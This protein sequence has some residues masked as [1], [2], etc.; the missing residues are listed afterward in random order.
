MKPVKN[1]MAFLLGTVV[2]AGTAQ[3][4]VAMQPMTF[5]IFGQYQTNRIFTNNLSTNEQRDIRTVEFSTVDV[6]KA[7]ALDHAGRHW[8]NLSYAIIARET[9]FN[10]GT[11]GREGIFLYRNSPPTN[12]NVSSNFALNFTNDFTQN[13][14]NIFPG[15]TNLGVNHTIIGGT[16]PSGSTN[17]GSLVSDG[18][19]SIT[20]YTTNMQ[21]NLIGYGT[22]TETNLAGS[23]AGVHYS[24]PVQTLR[25]LTGVGTFGLNIA[26]NFF[27]NS[28]VGIPNSNFVS[29]PAHGYFRTGAPVF[30]TNSAASVFGP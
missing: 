10:N 28:I 19:F 12:V 5:V 11:A 6:H 9:E 16:F 18:L 27:T 23:H 14:T 30:I 17:L 7:L 22:T 15:V 26:T 13:V 20:L 3:A 8:T 29:G 4:Q 21:F 25:V 2:A 24:G 1:L